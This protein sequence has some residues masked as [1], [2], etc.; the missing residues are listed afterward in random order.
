VVHIIHEL[1]NQ[2]ESDHPRWPARRNA[3]KPGAPERALRRRAARAP[4]STACHP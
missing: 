1:Q 2:P 3:V 4:I